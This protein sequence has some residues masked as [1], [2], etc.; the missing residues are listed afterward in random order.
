MHVIL[1]TTIQMARWREFLI[2]ALATLPVC[3][4][5]PSRSAESQFRPITDNND[6]GLTTI[7][8][9]INENVT[10][11][12]KTLPTWACVTS[13]SHQKQYTGYVH[14]PPE[15]LSPI[16]QSYPINTFFWFVEARQNADTAPLTIYLNGGPG[17]SSMTGL[18]QEVGP[19]EA[20]EISRDCIGTRAREWGW[21]RASNLLFID[22][23]VQTG[24]SY[25]S[26]RN[27]SLDLLSSS[28]TFPPSPVPSRHGEGLVLNGTFSSRNADATANTTAIAS[29]TVWHMLQGF[30]SAFP[31]YNPSKGDEEDGSAAGIHLFTES[32]GG[33]YGPAFA[34]HWLAQNEARRNGK[35]P[36]E[37]T[38]EINL[39]SVGI[40]QGCIDDLIQE[41]FYPIFAYNNTYGIQAISRAEMDAS[42]AAFEK[43]DGCEERITACR[44]KALSL[45]P[46]GNG[47]VDAVIALCLAAMYTCYNDIFSPFHKSNR[48]EYDISQSRLSSFSPLTHLTYLNIA[49][50]QEALGVQVNYTD[51]SKAVQSAF[52]STGD[53]MRTSYVPHLG[54]L[55]ASGVRVALIHGDRDYVC[56]WMGGEAVSLAIASSPN[57]PA[58][59]R[60][61]NAFSDIAG[62][63]PLTITNGA[64]GSSYVGGT[65]RQLGNLSFTRVYDAGHFVPA[66]QPETA[67]TLFSRIIAGGRDLGSGDEVDLS[68]FHTM[69]SRNSTKTNVAPPMAETICYVRAV[70]AT[71]SMEQKQM[72]KEGRGVVING[73][74]Y[75]DQDEW[76]CRRG[77]NA[78]KGEQRMRGLSMSMASFMQRARRLFA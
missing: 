34:E 46:A 18:F 50:V 27:G 16:R 76:A 3:T 21:D 77:N 12:Y 47:D 10:I 63:A 56:N 6:A 30:L 42:L 39:Q 13:S 48:S 54:S 43:K 67:F 15:A 64:S 69:G 14:L 45:D 20:V 22:Q 58:P 11:S 4:A 31:Q 70:E 5:L 23:P 75:K 66:A 8:S 51:Y 53:Y 61:K 52:I 65:V 38:L 60:E 29:R 33:K 1:I 28:Y 35:L 25:D 9:P 59:Y 41:P 44:S 17:A 57:A 74:L 78:S 26:L 71:C 62:Y 49:R 2:W 55:L 40:L 32:Y 68:T 72:L 36:K 7:R 37:T 73:V 19:C 24:F